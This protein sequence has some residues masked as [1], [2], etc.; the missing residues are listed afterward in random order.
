MS[1]MMVRRSSEGDGWRRL[2]VFGEWRVN[3]SYIRSV[4]QEKTASVFV[5]D[6]GVSVVPVTT[7]WVIT[8]NRLYIR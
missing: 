1:L 3:R 7:G 8:P 5:I 6:E 2:P 4:N